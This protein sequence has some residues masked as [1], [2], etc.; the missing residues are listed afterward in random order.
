MYHTAG[1]DTRFSKRGGDAACTLQARYER[2]GGGGGHLNCACVTQQNLPTSRACYNEIHVRPD[3][4]WEH[5]LQ[6]WNQD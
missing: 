6:G 4:D 5:K 3:S 1:A 2:G